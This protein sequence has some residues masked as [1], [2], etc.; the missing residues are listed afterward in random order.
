[1]DTGKSAFNFLVCGHRQLSEAVFSGFLSLCA[2]Q[3]RPQVS[4]RS[5][6][7]GETI[8]WVPPSLHFCHLL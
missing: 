2:E 7:Y 8:G 6:F 4:N 5:C 1:M 3:T